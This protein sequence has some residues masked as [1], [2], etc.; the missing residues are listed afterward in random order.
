MSV[1]NPYPRPTY[2]KKYGWF[3][4]A[5]ADTASKCWWYIGLLF[6]SYLAKAQQSNVAIR[7]CGLRDLTMPILV[8]GTTTKEIDQVLVLIRRAGCATSNNT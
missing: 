1:Y 4:E 7:C 3:I 5:R 6:R 2:Q 8:A